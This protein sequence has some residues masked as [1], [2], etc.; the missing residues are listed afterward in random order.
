MKIYNFNQLNLHKTALLERI[1]MKRSETQ[2]IIN[3]VSR[4][5][6][7]SS[8]S[9][10]LVLWQSFPTSGPR[11]SFRSVKHF[12][13]SQFIGLYLKMFPKIN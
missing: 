1:I 11:S 4:D 8:L 13:M 10:R 3:D 2:N 12:K 6:V 5:F 9:L 7:N